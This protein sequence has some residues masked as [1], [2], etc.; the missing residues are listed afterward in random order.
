MDVSSS[1]AEVRRLEEE[2]LPA[3]EGLLKDLAEVSSSTS[4]FALEDLALL[5]REMSVLPEVYLNLVAV[6]DGDVVGFISLIF[7]KTLFH[8]GGT[9]LINELVVSSK[10]RGLGIGGLLV[11]AAKEAALAR[12][13]DELEVG[14]ERTNT[15]AQAF[16]RKCGFDEEYVL[17]GMEF[18][19][20]TGP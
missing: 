17:L 4:S 5:F 14:T 12:G 9:A 7:Y 3:V 20:S 6:A 19:L 13:M 10:K 1:K 11:T 15:L 2:D 18:H 8:K 16:Y